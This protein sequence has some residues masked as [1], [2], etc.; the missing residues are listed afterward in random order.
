MVPKAYT[1]NWSDESLP[2][3]GHNPETEKLSGPTEHLYE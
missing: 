1:F 2:A 3:T